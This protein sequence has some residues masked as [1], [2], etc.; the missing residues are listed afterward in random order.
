MLKKEFSYYLENQ[1]KL[2]KEYSNKFI[3]IKDQSVKG[4]Y[5]SHAEA[6]NAAIKQ[7]EAGTFLIQHCM[8][9]AESYTQTFHSR[10]IINRRLV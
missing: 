5:N 3:V 2:L 9:G 6:Y 8:P 7:F 4:A 1:D 10:A